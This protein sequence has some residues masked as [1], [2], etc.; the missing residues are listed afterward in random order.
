MSDISHSPKAPHFIVSTE[1]EILGHETA[2]NREIVRRIHA[3]MNACEGI[4]TEEL[5][6][7]IIQDMQRVLAGVVPLLQEKNAQLPVSQP[8]VGKEQSIPQ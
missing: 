4:S 3:C 7:G 5:E 8:T 6:K 1:G 2:E